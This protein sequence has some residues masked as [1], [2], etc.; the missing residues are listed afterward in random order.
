MKWVSLEASYLLVTY[1][2]KL[3]FDRKEVLFALMVATG[4]LLLANKKLEATAS[5]MHLSLQYKVIINSANS[6]T[7]RLEFVSS[8]FNSWL[9]CIDWKQTTNNNQLLLQHQ[10]NSSYQ[11]GSQMAPTNKL[12]LNCLRHSFHFRWTFIFQTSSWFKKYK[13]TLLCCCG[14]NW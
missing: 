10:Q 5:Q 1:K 9:V 7:M 11:R 2:Y 13:L 14:A 8:N 6:A 4:K 3:L 12:K